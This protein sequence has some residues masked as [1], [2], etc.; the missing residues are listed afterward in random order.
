[1]P[2]IFR[3]IAK[4]LNPLYECRKYRISV[5]Q[6]PSFLFLL[7]GAII[8]AVI[9]ATYFIATLKIHNPE[10]VSLIVLVVAFVLLIIDY[11]ITKSF[12][13][14]SEASRI[15]TEFISITSHELR[16]PLTNLRFTLDLISSDNREK[17]IKEVGNYISILKDNVERMN[18]LIN[19]LLVVSRLESEE[20]I[21]K[22]EEINPLEIIKKV[23]LSYKK[24]AESSNTKIVLEAKKNMPKI[25]TDGFWF[26]KIMENLIDNSIRYINKE[27]K[28][29]I[30]AK[31]EKGKA[32]FSVKDNGFGIPKEEQKFIFQRFF[33][34][35]NALRYQTSGTGLSLYISKKILSLMGGKIWFHSGENKGAEFIFSL[36]TKKAAKQK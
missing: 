13:K 7:M 36:P 9:I 10:I 20:I 23:I 3:K 32:I 33:R 28:I 2:V 21:I 12:E 15:K 18:K 5:W 17:K 11:I 22:N 1:M 27:G 4:S 8:I 14:L 24:I 29:I 26:K 6:C 31:T 30:K 25:T 35:K 16:S 19:N 34:S